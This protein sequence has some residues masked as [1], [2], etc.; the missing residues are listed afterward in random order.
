MAELLSNKSV[1][2]SPRAMKELSEAKIE[3]MSGGV[4]RGRERNLGHR[5]LMRA[6][7]LPCKSRL[8]EV[9]REPGR[10]QRLVKLPRGRSLMAQQAG[11][12]F[13]NRAGKARQEK[14]SVTVFWT[15]TRSSKYLGV[16]EAWMGGIPVTRTTRRFFCLFLEKETRIAQATLEPNQREDGSFCVDCGLQKHLKKN[17]DFA[18]FLQFTVSWIGCCKC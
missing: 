1:V 18:K 10:G 3:I 8:A 12:G 2:C 14:S 16:V 11:A 7:N 15:S 6:G 17:T 9:W 5:Q 13:L 4:G